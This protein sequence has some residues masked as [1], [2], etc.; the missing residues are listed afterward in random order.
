MK[1]LFIKYPVV[2]W[3]ST[4]YIFYSVLPLIGTVIG[5]SFGEY[6]EI[7]G[8]TVFLWPYPLALALQSWVSSS[9]LTAWLLIYLVGLGLVILFGHYL[10]KIF[11]VS[12][13]GKWYSY[14]W[15]IL[16]WPI[17]LVL[18]Q[19]I[20]AAFVFFVLGLPVGE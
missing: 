4:G 17:P 19:V 14:V 16:L 15:F 6:G 13:D 10:Q 2:S 20:T 9:S 7:F 5:D 12:R 8:F 1:H 3:I 18:L 11:R